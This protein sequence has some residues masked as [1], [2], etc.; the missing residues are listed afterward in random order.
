MSRFV[1]IT[2]R[3]IASY[4]NNNTV[5][6]CDLDSAKKNLAVS[7]KCSDLHTKK[8]SFLLFAPST[9]FEYYFIFNTCSQDTVRLIPQKSLSARFLQRGFENLNF[10]PIAADQPD[11]DGK[12]F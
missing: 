11:K 5:S 12:K 4:F 9:R 6:M 3:L 1:A 7:S 2:Q 8:F 10:M